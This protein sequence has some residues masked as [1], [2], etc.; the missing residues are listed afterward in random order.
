LLVGKRRRVETIV[1]QVSIAAERFVSEAALER[2]VDAL[3]KA[4]QLDPTVERDP[5]SLIDVRVA[6]LRR[7][8]K[9]MKLY[10]KPVTVDLAFPRIRIHRGGTGWY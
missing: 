2:V 4:G 6:E 1:L 7:D 10:H 3:K 9:S 5:S 8:I